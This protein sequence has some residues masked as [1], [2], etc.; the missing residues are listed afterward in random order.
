MYANYLPITGYFNVFFQ[1]VFWCI[2]FHNE[3]K[4]KSKRRGRMNGVN[5]YFLAQGYKLIAENT[6]GI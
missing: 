5:I 6:T 2:V 1:E 3:K 4:K